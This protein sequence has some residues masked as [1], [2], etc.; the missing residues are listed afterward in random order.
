MGMN[1]KKEIKAS[2]E[3]LGLDLSKTNTCDFTQFSYGK[4]RQL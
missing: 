4:T 3:K 1:Y 2:I